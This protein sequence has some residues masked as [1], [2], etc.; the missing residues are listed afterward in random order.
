[1]GGTPRGHRTLPY[2]RA[3]AWL[4][5]DEMASAMPGR[6]S[7]ARRFAE[8]GETSMSEITGIGWQELLILLLALGFVPQ[9][10]VALLIVLLFALG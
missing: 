6:A 4:D 10:V 3:G 1:M 2:D 7:V 5:A 8:E 9:E